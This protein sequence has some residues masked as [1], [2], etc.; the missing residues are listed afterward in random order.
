MWYGLCCGKF[1]LP[2][3]RQ[4]SRTNS[5]SAITS[6]PG[7]GNKYTWKMALSFP[8][9]GC[10][11]G[12]TRQ[13]NTTQFIMG[14]VSHA[15]LLQ[16]TS[17]WIMG[18]HAKLRNKESTVQAAPSRLRRGS[19]ARS[20]ARGS[21]FAVMEEWL[22]KQKVGDLGACGVLLER[23]GQTSHGDVMD[24]ENESRKWISASQRSSLECGGCPG[25][26]VPA[27]QQHPPSKGS[28]GTA[29]VGEGP[30]CV[31][32][33]AVT[34]RGKLLVWRM[35]MEPIGRSSTPAGN[36][37][38]RERP[39]LSLERAGSSPDL[40]ATGEGWSQ[41]VSTG[42]PKQPGAS[43][44][45]QLQCKTGTSGQRGNSREKSSWPCAVLWYW[46]RWGLQSY[47]EKQERRISTGTVKQSWRASTS[48]GGGCVC[49]WIG[50]AVPVGMSVSKA[51][52][53]GTQGEWLNKQGKTF[54]LQCFLM[55]RWIFP[56]NWE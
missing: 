22:I 52:P 14:G 44:S 12:S 5:F 43:A 11:H 1:S 55:P 25:V 33:A 21:Y 2:L 36:W 41:E 13:V 24:L 49:R 32:W 53:Q 3:L 18:S 20:Q 4:E 7:W 10:Q 28:T 46:G 45:L 30:C 8:L 26:V 54:V 6:C 29:G 38:T 47:L 42:Q 9:P 48:R 37:G 23:A 40:P 39:G 31:P 19:R 35:V 51:F 15:E 17:E 27:R 16:T 50:A 34:L 56:Q